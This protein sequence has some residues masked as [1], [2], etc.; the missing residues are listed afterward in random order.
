MTDAIQCSMLV[1]I[2]FVLGI[3]IT[4]FALSEQRL[5]TKALQI[6]YEKLIKDIR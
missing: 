4:L 3:N 5:E 2:A 1:I 6:S